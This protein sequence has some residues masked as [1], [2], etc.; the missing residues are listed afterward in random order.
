[1]QRRYTAR[2]AVLLVG[3]W[4]T[5]MLGAIDGPTMIVVG[6]PMVLLVAIGLLWPRTPF[7]P[8]QLAPVGSAICFE[9]DSI[10]LSLALTE[11]GT[12]RYRVEIRTGGVLLQTLRVESQTQTVAVVFSHFGSYRL[13]ESRLVREG[14]FGLFD[15]L[16]KPVSPTPVKVF[17]G[18]EDVHSITRAADAQFAI[19]R[20]RSTMKSHA[21]LEFVDVRQAVPGDVLADVNWKITARTGAVWLNQRSSD[22]PLDLIILLDTFPS[23]VLNSLTRMAAN[24]ARAHLRNFDRVGLVVF[25]GTIGW[26]PP[27]SGRYQER[28]IAERLLLV[29]PYETAA[30]KRIDLLPR[31]AI[32]RAATVVVM[33]GL[34]DRR[35]V[36]AIKDLRFAG[37]QLTVVGPFQTQGS[38]RGTSLAERLT[39]LIG[40]QLLEDITRL[41][42][43]VVDVKDQA[44]STIVGSTRVD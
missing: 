8:F 37:H 22:L 12:Q 14:P 25:G 16:V 11:L 2:F 41:G 13:D 39:T 9:G 20:H 10:E 6:A 28:L 7:G 5:L 24:Y 27:A 17:P 26:I 33:S 4:L 34:H 21:G 44:V 3:A 15:D 32:P 42:V 36:Q 38:A 18:I 31:N 43:G 1:M 19:G 30:D 35:I 40:H 23:K 29:K